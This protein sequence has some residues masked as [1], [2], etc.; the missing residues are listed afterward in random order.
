MNVD[1]HSEVVVEK[2]GRAGILTL[3]RPAAINAL[4]HGMVRIIAR[5][6]DEWRDDPD[7]RTIVIRGAGERGLC[8]GGDIVALYNDAISGSGRSA[9]AFWRDEYIMNATIAT[10]P[11]PIVALQDGIVLGGGIGVSAHAS[12]RV[13]TESSRLGF[14]EVTIGFVPDVGATWL[15][16]RAPGQLGRRLALTGEHLTGGDAIAV[17]FADHFVHRDALPALMEALESTPPNEAIAN[18]AAPSPP[19]A[20]MRTRSW[21]DAAF[22]AESVPEILAR[23]GHSPLDEAGALAENIATKSPLALA[24]T[25]ESLRR[26]RSVS[27]L[28]EALIS[29]FR[30]STHAVTT[31]DFIEGVRA[32]VIDKDRN[33]RWNPTSLADVTED[34]VAAFF[35]PPPD[36]DLVFPN[37]VT[38][39]DP[40]APV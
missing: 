35:E 17:G 9:A 5:A 32:Q 27:S 14:P 37:V 21:V 19:S 12:H 13:V 38:K 7:V 33:P 36:G 20:L 1:A 8:S 11:K 31:H 3:N 15:L 24:V 30:V 40:Y 22:A 34:D 28:P 25:L 23:L 29:E 26:V 6:L 4:T 10:Y 18:C 2:R 16:S 39:G